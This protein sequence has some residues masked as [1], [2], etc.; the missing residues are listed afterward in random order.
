MT[1]G[2][3]K[4]PAPFSKVSP[5]LPHLSLTLKNSPGLKSVR[6]PQFGQR[7]A[8]A[9]SMTLRRVTLGGEAGEGMAV[10]GFPIRMAAGIPPST[11]GGSPAQADGAFTG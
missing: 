3:R 6:S 2:P 7:Q 9:R 10:K 1:K 4:A 8:R 11:G 5:Q